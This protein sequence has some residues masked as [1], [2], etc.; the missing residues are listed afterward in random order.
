MWVE[1]TTLGGE[2]R[3]HEDFKA[4]IMKEGDE[5][6]VDGMASEAVNHSTVIYDEDPPAP[7][8]RERRK[9]E[10]KNGF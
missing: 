1:A 4:E 8:T 10:G 2:T 5:E 7:A 6:R 9:K 3:T